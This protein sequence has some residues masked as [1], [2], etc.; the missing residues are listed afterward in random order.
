MYAWKIKIVNLNNMFYWCEKKYQKID[1]NQLPVIFKWR[2][3]I[4]I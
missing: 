2:I 3:F 4:N 1:K